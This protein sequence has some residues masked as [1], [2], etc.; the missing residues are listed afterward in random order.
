MCVCCL[1]SWRYNPLWLYFHSPVAGFSLL[2]FEVS[3]SNTTT[4]HRTPLGE[5]SIRRRDLYLHNT[6]HSQQ[7]N[8]HAPGGIRTHNFSS[9]ADEDLRLRPRGHWDR[10]MCVCSLS[11]PACKGHAP[12]CHLWPVRIYCILPN[13]LI[14]GT[15]F[16]KLL[17]NIKCVFWFSLQILSENFLILRRIQIDI[18]TNV[19]RSSCAYPIFL[20][21]FNE[22]WIFRT[23]FS[24]YI[25]TKFNENVFSGS[26]VFPCG[27][28][29]RHDETNNSF[30]QICESAQIGGISFIREFLS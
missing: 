12:Y 1:F 30:S 5:W 24:K 22:T 19:H 6:Q 9:R 28:R 20:L 23:D 17:L 25:Q 4:R 16:G 27:R 29:D 11:Y 14:N 8:I 13:Y 21:D 3:W 26:R 7:T 10:R 18:I 15:I 2:V